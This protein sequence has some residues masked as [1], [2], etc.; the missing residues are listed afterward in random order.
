MAA[1][2]ELKNFPHFFLEYPPPVLRAP[3]KLIRWNIMRKKVEKSFVGVKISFRQFLYLSD[4]GFNYSDDIKHTEKRISVL[5]W[6]YCCCCPQ[7]WRK[8]RFVHS[9]SPLGI[10]HSTNVIK[11]FL[12]FEIHENDLDFYRSWLMRLISTPMENP[13][14]FVEKSLHFQCVTVWDGF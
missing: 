12:V 1:G 9:S 2:D 13:R 14:F 11:P 4:N 3:S 8:P 6:L 5:N 7:F 10:E